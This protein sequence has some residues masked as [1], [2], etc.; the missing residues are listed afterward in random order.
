MDEKT[1]AYLALI[2]IFAL[3]MASAS[4]GCYVNGDPVPCDSGFFGMFWAVFIVIFIIAVVFFI[5]WLWMLIDC[6][7]RDFKDKVLWILLLLLVSGIGAI[8]YYFLVK[9]K[10]VRDDARSEPLR[11][12]PL[13][14]YNAASVDGSTPTKEEKVRFLVDYVKGKMANGEDMNAVLDDLSKK[15]LSA[16]DR[17]KIIKMIVG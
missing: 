12:K 16:D 7:K 6:I 9:R 13:P 1:I 2:A 15:G 4:M 10:D 3:P 8:L 17:Q 5:F 11:R 14:V